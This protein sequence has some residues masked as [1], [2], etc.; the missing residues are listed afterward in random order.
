[1]LIRFFSLI[2]VTLALSVVALSSK[3][4]PSDEYRKAMNT[5]DQSTGKLEKSIQ[6][7][8]HK[9]MNEQIFLVRPIIEFLQQFWR[10]RGAEETDDAHV[11]IK[12]AAKSISELSVSAHLLSISPNPV[13]VDGAKIALRTLQEACQTCHKSHRGTQEDGSF[14]IK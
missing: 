12:A 13:A 10:E 9:L 3:E 11:A 6:E 14:I 8:D 7:A 2:A 4:Q 1:M 5:L